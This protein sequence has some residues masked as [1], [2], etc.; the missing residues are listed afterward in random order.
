MVGDII[1]IAMVGGDNKLSGVIDAD[2][3][4]TNAVH[5][6]DQSVKQSTQG[7]SA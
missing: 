4:F 2:G 1:L 6:L 7:E 5:P 3:F